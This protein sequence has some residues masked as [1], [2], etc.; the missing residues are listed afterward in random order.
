MNAIYKLQNDDSSSVASLDL[1]GDPLNENEVDTIDESEF[2]I[3]E[4]TSDLPTLEDVLAE[5]FDFSPSGSPSKLRLQP[6]HERYGSISSFG[7]YDSI[8][9]AFQSASSSKSAELSIIK[10]IMLKGVSANIGSAHKRNAGF[11]SAMAANKIIAIGTTF[12]YLLLFDSKQLLRFFLPPP[13]DCGGISALSLNV[14]ASRV[15]AGHERGTVN[16]WDTDSGKVLRTFSYMANI[17]VL[18][19]KF[20]DDSTKALMSNSAG[21]VLL[22]SFRR[23][24]GYRVCDFRPIFAG[25]DVVS[26]EPLIISNNIT[27]HPL[28]V[29]NPFV[30]ALATLSKFIVVILRPKLAKIFSYS[31]EGHSSTLPV[32]SWQFIKLQV[33]QSSVSFDPV[34]LFGRDSKII[35]AL[36]K[37]SNTGAT[38]MRVLKTLN[39]GYSLTNLIWFNNKTI[40][41]PDQKE[42][43]H[44]VDIQ[45]EEVIETLD[46]QSVQLV[47]STAA[48][49]GLAADSKNNPALVSAS[50]F[51]CYYSLTM[52]SRQLL[53]LG[54]QSLH[55]FVIRTWY[56]RV[57]VL[58]KARMYSEAVYLSREVFQGTCKAVVGALGPEKLFLL[59][60]TTNLLTEY[61]SY[62][63]NSAPQQGSVDALEVYYSDI[64][65]LILET[66]CLFQLYDFTND[67]YNIFEHDI[68]ART[69]FL[70]SIQSCVLSDRISKVSPSILKDL[71]N[72]NID[73]ETISLIQDIILKLDISTI[74][75]DQ[76]VKLSWQ[77]KLFD[78]I[79]YL[80]NRAIKNYSMPLEEL[81]QFLRTK[82][83]KNRQLVN[84]IL[85]YLSC[86]MTGRD[87]IFGNIPEQLCRNAKIQSWK[88][89]LFDQPNLSPSE[90]F[91]NSKL[92]LLS[93]TRE[94]LNVLS[95]AFGEPEFLTAEGQRVR[96]RIIDMVMLI[97]DLNESEFAS[98]QLGSI[99]VFLA[100][101]LMK[102]SLNLEP[103]VF[104][105]VVNYLTSTKQELKA[106]KIERERVVTE[107]LIN[108]VLSI[109]D[110]NLEEKLL[111]ASFYSVLEFV[112][113][114]RGE[115]HKMLRCFCQVSERNKV[116]FRFVRSVL[117]QLDHV[118]EEQK[119]LLISEINQ[120]ISLLIQIDP[121]KA[122]N[123]LL[124]GTT[125]NLISNIVE[126]YYRIFINY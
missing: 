66:C 26:L 32:I 52:A 97:V 25:A 30:I 9:P 7:S 117:Y 110:V 125:L 61:S 87:Y 28:N 92:L 116:V 42:N 16:M 44:L 98:T 88:F 14:D 34:V 121:M 70:S 102:S 65:P 95:I 45:S 79:I 36:L 115:Y 20:T 35:F 23:P 85:V 17:P 80:Y 118:T 74:D 19:I 86:C 21:Y 100:R 22:M 73:Q 57:N 101:E 124:V 111:T 11:P 106:T 89:L 37:T 120:N 41:V 59:Q 81:T 51:A 103:E 55:V 112:Y 1:F 12:G 82:D 50:G 105:Q 63:I 6:K 108:G 69:V 56:E 47:Y 78:A 107:L 76:V 90:R 72:Q 91:P 13:D 96:Q 39:L 64:V 104:S 58:K 18:H 67:I 54:Q 24:L 71:I 123:L 83:S 113:E 119:Q 93:D 8:Q 62:A 84:T 5:N 2:N 4:F 99:Y 49:K 31:L 29:Y 10:H 126:I 109:D 68:T 94:F 40:A 48:F 53:L 43:L 75:I 27:N 46:L 77:N 38:G 122:A 114:K 3:P 15:L 60:S 33:N